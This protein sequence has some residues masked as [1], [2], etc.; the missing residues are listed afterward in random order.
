MTRIVLAVLLAIGMA[1]A[2]ACAA[3]SPV[4]PDPYP[5]MPGLASC[6]PEPPDP[7]TGLAP[8]PSRA[9]IDQINRDVPI[10]F[11]GDPWPD[12]RVCRAADGSA[13][14][15][16]VQ[17][18]LYMELAFMR[19]V[20]FSKQLPWTDMS[21]YDWFRQTVAGIVVEAKPG[22]GSYCCSPARVIHVVR[23]SS[24]PWGWN[25]NWLTNDA[26]IPSG[27]IHEARHIEAGIH[28]CGSKDNTIAEMGTF[29]VQYYYLKWVADYSDEPDALKLQAAHMAWGLRGSGFCNECS[30]AASQSSR[31]TSF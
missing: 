13:D 16:Y 11:A 26:A 22:G 9:E 6:G 24:S 5:P 20:S 2:L 31:T 10:T 23:D 28:S 3:S 30:R 21:A 12:S 1:L 25:S 29:G 7:P 17:A 18:A 15:T 4:K 8:C 19:R 14:L 27:L